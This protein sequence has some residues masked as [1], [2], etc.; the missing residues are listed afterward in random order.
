MNTLHPLINVLA[1]DC[2]RVTRTTADTPLLFE[3][4]LMGVPTGPTSNAA[5]TSNGVPI[6]ELFPISERTIDEW[7]DYLNHNIYGLIW[8]ETPEEEKERGA[9]R[10]TFNDS[11]ELAM[12]DGVPEETLV[13][14]RAL[15][16]EMDDAYVT[17]LKNVHEN[18]TGAKVC[19]IL[20]GHT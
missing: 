8:G 14:A 16:G 4:Y 9:Y 1:F 7:S 17:N 3:R 2:G 5:K 13:K 6:P 19:P 10:K 20:S 11:K 18:I 15:Q 12:V